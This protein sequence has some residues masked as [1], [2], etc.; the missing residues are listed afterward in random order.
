MKLLEI[1]LYAGLETKY[2]RKGENNLHTCVSSYYFFD[3]DEMI[4]IILSYRK[5]DSKMWAED[6]SNIVKTFK[7]NNK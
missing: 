7:W 5:E 1:Q 4:N 2:V 3:N 6:F